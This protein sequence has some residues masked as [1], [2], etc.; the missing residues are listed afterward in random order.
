MTV[1]ASAGGSGTALMNTCS[2]PEIVAV[3][4]PAASVVEVIDTL[5]EPGMSLVPGA[6]RLFD[7][8]TADGELVKITFPLVGS[9][10]L[11]V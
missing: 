7:R 2:D 1:N 11:K 9:W 8:L 4:V 6:L 5:P 10:M 3:Y